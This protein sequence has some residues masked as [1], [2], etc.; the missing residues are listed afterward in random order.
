VTP[1]A[2]REWIQ[3]ALDQYD[4]DGDRDAVEAEID[5]AFA[6][7]VATTPPPHCQTCGEPHGGE[8]PYPVAP[9]TGADTVGLREALERIAALEPAYRGS[10]KVARDIARAALAAPSPGPAEQPDYRPARDKWKRE[11]IEKF[12]V[13]SA[14]SEQA[15]IE[16]FQAAVESTG[17]AEEAGGLRAALERVAIYRPHGTY[18]CCRGCGATGWPDGPYVGRFQHRRDCYVDAALAPP[19][20][21]E[22]A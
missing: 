8:C 6:A 1:E 15:F 14:T 10:A 19:T 3:T 5:R 21:K 20:P 11:W 4:L 18:L 12:A 16:G 9:P 13:V 17:P 22:S 2:L 7:S